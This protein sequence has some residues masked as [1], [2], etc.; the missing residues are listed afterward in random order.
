MEWFVCAVIG[1]KWKASWF[2]DSFW[3]DWDHVLVDEFGTARIT[4]FTSPSDASPANSPRSFSDGLSHLS[5][6]FLDLI[7]QL[8]LSYCL[9][10]LIEHPSRRN[11][12]S[13]LLRQL[14]N[15]LVS[16]GHLVPACDPSEFNKVLT[17]ITYIT[18][19]NI[20]NDLDLYHSFMW[21]TTPAYIAMKMLEDDYTKHTNRL[22]DTE[23]DFNSPTF[24]RFFRLVNHELVEVSKHFDPDLFEEARRISSW[25]QLLQKVADGKEVMNDTSFLKLPFFRPTLLSLRTKFQQVASSLDGSEDSS[26]LSLPSSYS[27]PHTSLEAL[28]DSSLRTHSSSSNFQQ[29]SLQLLTVLHPLLTS[30]LPRSPLKRAPPDNFSPL[31]TRFQNDPINPHEIFSSSLFDETDTEKLTRSLI[32]CHSVCELV[33]AEKCIRDIPEFFDRT[34][35]VLG[36]SDS[37]LRAAANSLFKSF[38]N[39]S[40]V[41]PILPDLWDRL[42]S[43]FRDGRLEEQLALIAISTNWIKYHHHGSP[44]PPFP[45]TEFDWDGLI[46]ADLS[47]RYPFLASILLILFL[48]H[49]LIEDQIGKAKA[50]DIILSFEQHQQAVSRIVSIF[51]EMQQQKADPE[52]F[53]SLISYCLRISL[54]SNREFPPSLKT[55]LRQHPEIEESDLLP[56]ENRSFLLCHSSVNRHKPHQPSADEPF[57]ESVWED[58]AADEFQDLLQDEK[59]D[60]TPHDLSAFEHSHTPAWNEIEAGVFSDVVQE[61]E[62]DSHWLSA[63]EHFHPPAL[64]EIQAGVFPDVM[65]EDEP[66]SHWLSASEHFHP[67]AWDDA[68]A[69]YIQ[70]V[71]DDDSFRPHEPCADDSFNELPETD[72]I[73]GKSDEPSDDA[74]DCRSVQGDP[75]SATEQTTAKQSNV[76]TDTDSNETSEA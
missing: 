5:L 45:A 35:S 15:H 11:E 31:V 39:T 30:P 66:D 37:F 75:K 74:A 42:R 21:M 38:V 14:I 68:A 7:R 18:S 53:L 9:P 52:K 47:E 58:A 62:P 1:L 20:S 4:L 54:L 34:V 73:I 61:D 6:L 46:S 16:T 43:A 3:F 24:T 59:T 28:L 36:S 70:F 41:I 49:P 40:D 76:S 50:T 17:D 27:S 25:R 8:S 10:T 69:D 44:L 23:F 19:D 13:Y 72:S 67:P 33:G 48:Q 63:S 22:T 2:D 57:G 51:A 26:M 12:I 55:F 29:E 64:N 71:M 60:S 32:R 56:H 65:Q